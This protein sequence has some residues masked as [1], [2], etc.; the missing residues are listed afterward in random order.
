MGDFSRDPGARLQ[1]SVAKHYVGVRLQQGVPLLDADWNE[2]EDLRRWETERVGGWFVGDGVPAGSDGFRVAGTGAGNDFTIVAGACLV[3][4]RLVRGDAD[5]RYS[6]QPAAGDPAVQPPLAPLATPGADVQLTAYLDAWE[7]EVSAQEDTDLVDP[8]IGVETTAR[9]VRL[10]AVRVT[11][12][13]PAAAAARPAGHDFYPLARIR[14]RAGVAAIEADDLTDL[15]RTDLTLSLGEGRMRVYGPTGI[16][17]Y[18]GASFA[19]L[20]AGA[21][22]AYAGLLYSDLFLADL[23]DPPTAVET[24][25]LL[26]AFQDVKTRCRMGDEA[27][28]RGIGN[29]GA[30]AVLGALQQVQAR[31]VDQLHP[32]ADGVPARVVTT[33]FLEG[34]NALLGET[35]ARGLRQAVA[36]EALREAIE[37]Q[38]A[39][40]NYIGGRSGVLPRGRV[41][42]T[43]VD[44]PPADQAITAPGVYRYVY[45]VLSEV[46]LRE[47]FVLEGRV[48]G[49]ADWVPALPATLELEPNETAVVNVDVALPGGT[50][51][52]Q[53]ALV[54]RVRSQLNPGQ[55]DFANNEVQVTL[56]A[57]P[58]QP[59]PLA[60]QLISPAINVAEDI[61]NVGRS[62][63]T[64]EPGK[65]VSGV[66]QVINSAQPGTPQD[67]TVQFAFSAPDVFDPIASQPLQLS[68]GASGQLPAMLQATA[69]SVN[70]T[71]ADLHVTVT[72]N[73]DAAVTQT[74]V[75]MLRVQKS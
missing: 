8:R 48:D 13:Y 16:V 36:D 68:G 33:Q 31:F 29:G 47:T 55:V 67:F 63:P 60:V 65:R 46:N 30:L 18:D 10:W 57:P 34:L 56:G 37:A 62:A 39:I 43:F 21:W 40:N 41:T 17:Q 53:G 59:V 9:T 51:S 73:D 12:D 1:D 50:A 71:R 32:L 15:R 69:G 72:R 20:C 2:L 25:T 64:G 23:F 28:R 4:G 52:T 58:P 45:E 61:L 3:A 35:P 24:V 22:T 19:L 75:V 7:R 49:A 38:Q 54:L 44:G 70:G 5:V 14:R 6:T 11:A 42:I 26:D 66:F 74:R 27:A